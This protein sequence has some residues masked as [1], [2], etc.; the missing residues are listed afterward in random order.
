MGKSNSAIVTVL[1]V[2]VDSVDLDSSI[3]ED[4][5]DDGEVEAAG[6]VPWR[7]VETGLMLCERETSILFSDEDR[8]EGMIEV[9]TNSPVSINLFLRRGYKPYK[10]SGDSHFFR[11]PYRALTIRR[12]NANVRTMTD[13]QRAA[14]VERLKQARDAKAAR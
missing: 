13:E 9:F 10:V 7:A 6:Y 3:L 2:E 8:Q 14:A 1:G 11:I 4:T 5:E 12:A